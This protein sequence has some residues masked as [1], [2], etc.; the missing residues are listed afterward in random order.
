MNLRCIRNSSERDHMTSAEVSS[1]SVTIEK[2]TLGQQRNGMEV[3]LA[4][5]TTKPLLYGRLEQKLVQLNERTDLC[6]V[7]KC[8]ESWSSWLD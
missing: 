2:A 4:G 3:G 5:W 7:E 8:S 1:N 6:N